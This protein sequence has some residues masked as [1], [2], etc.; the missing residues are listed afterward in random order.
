MSAPSP[1]TTSLKNT[2]T[3]NRK[4]IGDINLQPD[5]DTS[6][7]TT[8]EVDGSPIN[9]AEVN[10]NGEE[11]YTPTIGSFFIDC[12]LIKN[13]RPG[14]ADIPENYFRPSPQNP[15]LV[16]VPLIEGGF[17]RFATS[18]FTPEAYDI[19]GTVPNQQSYA[20]A[21]DTGSVKVNAR[22]Q[23][24]SIE[25][26]YTVINNDYKPNFSPWSSNVF[27]KHKTLIS[28]WNPYGLIR[29]ENDDDGNVILPEDANI[30]Y[31]SFIA[32]GYDLTTGVVQGDPEYDYGGLDGGFYQT[33]DPYYGANGNN[34]SGNT[35][36]DQNHWSILDNEIAANA[37]FVLGNIGPDAV[38]YN[39]TP[40]STGYFFPPRVIASSRIN[41]SPDYLQLT[42]VFQFFL[43]NWQCFIKGTYRIY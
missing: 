20:S 8:L 30:M 5:F 13:K 37:P 9:P 25:L 2:A 34:G 16:E 38:L 33:Q 31:H 28:T 21:F 42:P 10:K 24:N 12:S 26:T 32:R 40:N 11:F 7:S 4:M 3:P 6:F 18:S 29:L 36:G 17:G 43:A 19:T 35:V 14:D 15:V 1:T 22:R 27:P 23:R 41:P 39:Q